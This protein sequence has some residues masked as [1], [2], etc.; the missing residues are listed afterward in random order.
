MNFTSSRRPRRTDSIIGSN[1]I[2]TRGDLYTVAIEGIGSLSNKRNKRVFDL[3]SSAGVLLLFPLAWLLSG[4]AGILLNALRVFSGKVSWVGYCPTASALN[5]LP[6]IKKGVLCPQDIFSQPLTDKE[7]LN[8]INLL[9]ARDYT[10]LKDVNILA[11]AFRKAGRKMT[12]H[13]Q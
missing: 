8:H 3:I 11:R 4:N 10:V 12:D 6:G 5:H 2:N 7:L 1:S 13:K 9:Y